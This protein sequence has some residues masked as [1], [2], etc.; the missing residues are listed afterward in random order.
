MLNETKSRILSGK[1]FSLVFVIMLIMLL[2]LSTS[3]MAGTYSGGDGLS[4]S[5]AYQIANLNDLQELQ[6]TSGDWRF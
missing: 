3:L 4:A 1:K 2:A 5:T 6:N